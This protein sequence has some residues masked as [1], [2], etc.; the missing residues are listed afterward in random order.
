MGRPVAHAAC[1]I[2]VHVGETRWVLGGVGAGPSMA[3]GGRGGR[4][5]RA[6]SAGAVPGPAARGAQLGLRQAGRG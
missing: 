5:L 1:Q 2:L 6:V 4:T 3:A